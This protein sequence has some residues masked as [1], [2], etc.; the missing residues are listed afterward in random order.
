MEDIAIITE[1]AFEKNC[2]LRKAEAVYKK[3]KSEGK[4]EEL[5]EKLKKHEEI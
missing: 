5:L 1:V 3:Y 2:S 4:L